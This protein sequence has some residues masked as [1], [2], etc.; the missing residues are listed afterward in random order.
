MLVA[1][2][3]SESPFPRGQQQMLLVGPQ[4]TVGAQEAVGPPTPTPTP[5]PRMPRS[6]CDPLEVFLQSQE[7]P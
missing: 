6:S 1:D 5:S 4:S 3:P 2:G 7:S